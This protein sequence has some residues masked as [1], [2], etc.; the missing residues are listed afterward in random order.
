M[1]SKGSWTA[2]AADSVAIAADESRG[3]VAIQHTGGDPV[4]LAFGEPAVVGLGLRLSSN[5]P[6]IAVDEWRARGAIHMIC[7]AGQSASGGWQA[8]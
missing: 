3:E 4:Y 8:K 5:M 7:D 1:S 2:T 6:F